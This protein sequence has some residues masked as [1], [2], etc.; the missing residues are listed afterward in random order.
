MAAVEAIA[1]EPSI[2]SAPEDENSRLSF[3]SA[4]ESQSKP[5]GEVSQSNDTLSARELTFSFEITILLNGFWLQFKLF[6]N[7]V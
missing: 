6:P 1:A 3:I 2:D 5:E 4:E 7:H